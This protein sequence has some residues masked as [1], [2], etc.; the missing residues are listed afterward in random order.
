MCNKP[1]TRPFSD[2]TSYCLQC[3]GAVHAKCQQPE[4][5]LYAVRENVGDKRTCALR[6]IYVMPK[7]FVAHAMFQQH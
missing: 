3:V 4:Q 7:T 2:E 5:E 1:C 6:E